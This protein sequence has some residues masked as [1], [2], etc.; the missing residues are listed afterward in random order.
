[1]IGCSL[2]DS[3]VD[4]RLHQ[5]SAS[6]P[7]PAPASIVPPYPPDAENM[8]QGNEDGRLSNATGN[9]TTPVGNIQNVGQNDTIRP[10]L[11]KSA[12]GDDEKDQEENV[13]LV[14]GPSQSGRTSVLMDLAMHLAAQTPCRC[15]DTNN[16]GGVS[17]QF[18]NAEDDEILTDGNTVCNCTA[19][20]FL[21]LASNSNNT[22]S[23]GNGNGGNNGS[24]RGADDHDRFP[25]TCYPIKQE[26]EDHQ[27]GNNNNKANSSNSRSK[28]DLLRR[29]QVL[30]VVDIQRAYTDLLTLQ[31]WP[32]TEQPWGGIIVDDLDKMVICRAGW[33]YY[34]YN[35]G[36]NQQHNN[37]ATL[38]AG[39]NN[40]PFA[41]PPRLPPQHHPMPN[42]AAP[43]F[44]S[45]ENHPR[46][47]QFCM[48]LEIIMKYRCFELPFLM[49]S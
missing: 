5:S 27:S 49:G 29:I 23:A 44:S 3:I 24:G 1:M 25:L 43:A 8:Q 32:I 38:G 39:A 18:T 48:Y 33:P 10:C 14:H 47:A 11:L 19:V 41:S 21:R 16:N 22:V 12:S 20:L 36:H 2:V 37:S 6:P 26:K 4:Q 7:R 28:D 34:Q 46:M 45:K 17:E 35:N 9:S 30:H 42:S 15:N 13:L 40:V 31:G